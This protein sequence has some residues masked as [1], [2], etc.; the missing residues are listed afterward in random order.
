MGIWTKKTVTLG[1]ECLIQNNIV[2]YRPSNLENAYGFYKNTLKQFTDSK[3][4]NVL[5][6]TP[7]SINIKDALG[8]H[9]FGKN[10]T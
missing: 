4:E 2:E 3:H 6:R 1:T 9:Q 10:K 5:T 8:L 7:F